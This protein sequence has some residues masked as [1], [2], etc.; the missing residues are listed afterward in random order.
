MNMKNDVGSRVVAKRSGALAMLPT[1][2]E[3][4]DQRSEAERVKEAKHPDRNSGAVHGPA[5]TSGAAGD[6]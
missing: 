1:C 5:W 4:D 3:R 6:H 2:A